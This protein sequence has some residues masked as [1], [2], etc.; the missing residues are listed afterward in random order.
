LK[1]ACIWFMEGR[2]LGQP[3]RLVVEDA[4][5]FKDVA[6]VVV[7]EAVVVEILVATVVATKM[8]VATKVEAT[9]ILVVAMVVVTISLNVRFVS[10][11]DTR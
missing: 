2:T 4:E 9:T 5:T 8:V 6:L 1:P 3:T 10:K 7:K 11:R